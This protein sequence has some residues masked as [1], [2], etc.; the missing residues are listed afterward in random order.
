MTRKE[1][2]ISQPSVANATNTV[3]GYV[4]YYYWLNYYCNPEN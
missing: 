4:E 3:T 1:Q 2:P